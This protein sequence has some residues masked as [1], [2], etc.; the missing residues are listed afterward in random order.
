MAGGM[1]GGG[2]GGMPNV[3]GVP[4]MMGAVNKG[5][6]APLG[7][8][9]M[10]GKMANRGGRMGFKRGGRASTGL[11]SEGKR[12]WEGYA[13]HGSEARSG[14]SGESRKLF[15][16]GGKINPADPYASGGKVDPAAPYGAATGMA[17][18]KQQHFYEGR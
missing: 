16:R 15:K 6:G 5:M 13:R 14:D 11:M 3:G 4:N 18:K 2:S 17:R 7:P 9:P 12:H 1:P 8:M 10:P